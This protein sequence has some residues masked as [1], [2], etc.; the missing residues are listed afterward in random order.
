MKTHGRQVHCAAGQPIRAVEKAKVDIAHANGLFAIHEATW[1]FIA[2]RPSVWR[3]VVKVYP[4]WLLMRKDLNSC[5][6]GQLV[7][8]S[9]RM[10]GHYLDPD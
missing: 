5:I 7:L 9:I 10:V 6:S 3:P 8:V 4:E 1:A 2:E